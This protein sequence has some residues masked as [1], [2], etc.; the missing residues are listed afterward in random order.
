MKMPQG[1]NESAITIPGEYERLP[2]GG[3]IC[4]I[5]KAVETVS[6][7]GKNMLEI[8][9]DIAEGE[10][11]GFYRRQYDNSTYDPKKWHNGAICRQG[12]EGEQLPNFKGVIS[13]IE[14]SNAGFKFDFDEKKLVGKYIGAIFGQEQY[15]AQNGELRFITRAR[16]LR[17]TDHIRKN[18][19]EVPKPKLLPENNGI[20]PQPKMEDITGE[21][22]PF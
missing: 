17:C 9:I 14:K 10:Y 20:P 21:D 11:T 19:F 1:Y 18:L 16:Y 12:T 15:R 22:L 2:D 8:Y 4:K 3:Y 6:K 13:E 5:V 7:N